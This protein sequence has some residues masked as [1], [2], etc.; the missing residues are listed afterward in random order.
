MYTFYIFYTPRRAPPPPLTRWSVEISEGAKLRS[1]S[2]VIKMTRAWGPSRAHV[3]KVLEGSYVYQ[4]AVIA[5]NCVWERKHFRV[6]R[7]WIRLGDHMRALAKSPR[8]H[9]SPSRARVVSRSKTSIYSIV[10]PCRFLHSNISSIFH[11][12]TERKDYL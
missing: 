2:G 5:N 6:P 8:C 1:A 11:S 3:C 12:Y 4:A 7:F 10:M 9:F